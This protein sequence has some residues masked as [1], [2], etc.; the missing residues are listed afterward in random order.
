MGLIDEHF[1]QQRDYLL[2]RGITP[3][4]ATDLGLTI[5]GEGMLQQRG[6]TWPGVQ[7]GIQWQVYDQQGNETGNT[8]ARVWY[9]DN[10]FTKKTVSDKPKFVT[11]KNQVPRLYHSPLQNYT[12]L[13][14]GDTIVLCESF[15]KADIAAL[16]GFKAVGVSG[17][18]GWSHNKELIEDFTRYDWKGLG[19]KLLICFD[20]NVRPDGGD[21]LALATERLAA[22]IERFGAKVHIAYLDPPEGDDGDWGLD[23]YYMS[24]G[25][26]GVV[27]LL[28][29]NLQ[30][31]YSSMTQHMTI[32]NREVAVVRDLAKVVDME[33]GTLMS[34]DAFANM[35]YADRLSW[36]RDGKPQSVSKSWLQWAERTEVNAMAYKPGQEKI[37]A[38]GDYNIWTGMGCEPVKNA[39]LVKLFTQWLDIAF[40]VEEEKHWFVCW[41]AYQVQH[42][43][44]K[45]TT[46]LVMVGDSGVGKGW[47]A[48]LM[49]IVFG[50]PNVA[51]VD[52]A[53]VGGR[54]NADYSAKQ[55]MLIEEAQMPRGAD[56]SVIYNKLK[57]VITNPF[58]RVER[59]GVDAFMVDNHVNLVM[60]GNRIDILK[61]DDFDRRFAVLNI[62]CNGVVNKKD[63]WLPRWTA[64]EAGLP[65]A[66][67][68]WLLEYKCKGFNPHGEAIRTTTR[69]E[70]IESTHNPREQFINELKSDPEE[71]LQVMGSVVDGVACTAKELE[72]IFQDGDTPL[73]ELDMS[74]INRMSRVLRLARFKRANDGS[75]IKANGAALLYWLV[76]P[77]PVSHKG[78]KHLVE[79]RKFWK[80]F[81]KAKV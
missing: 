35:V 51:S 39:R 50:L 59:K 32:M 5:C 61:L 79:T 11:P 45:L 54:F 4:V 43:G 71:L 49:R 63:Y 9:V 80:Q 31:V 7:R 21:L 23:D 52:L 74:D 68:A 69:D 37:T 56:G 40:P 1:T 22:E 72:Y 65:E 27:E 6:I 8:G 33:R 24:E 81:G 20:S 76:R 30:P 14:Q 36:D 48:N 75:K 3:E 67:Y 12:K 66:V 64:L 41:W 26:K 77:E 73:W 19:L 16:C 58:L 10:G 25:R 46:A 57:D 29:K 13:R 34:R 60:Q 55:L 2:D 28:T 53:S 47:F 62:D 42:L 38:G 17:V 44:T 78:W 18:W 15:L 70:M